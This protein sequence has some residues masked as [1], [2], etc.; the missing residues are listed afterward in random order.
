MIGFRAAEWLYASKTFAAAMLALAIGFSANLDRP[1]WAM[2][3][4]YIASQPQAGATRSKAAYRLMGTLLGAAAA[5]AMVPNLVATPA[6][7][8]GAL[9]GWVAITLTLAL[10]DRTPRGYVFML[11]GYS[12]AIIGFSSVNAPGAIFN[13]A[14]ARAEEIGVGV[15]CAAL[16]SSLVFPRHIG[17]VFLERTRKWLHD[18]Q[19]WAVDVLSQRTLSAAGEADRR[20]LAGD[21]IDIGVLTTQL[22][23]DK[24]GQHVSASA[25]EALQARLLMLLPLLSSISARLAALEKCGAPPELPAILSQAARFIAAAEASAT[26]RPAPWLLPRLA[27]A[28]EASGWPEIL[29]AGLLE[30][31]RELHAVFADCGALRAHLLQ[32]RPGLP[33]LVGGSEI[34]AAALQHTDIRMA[35]F[36]GLSAGLAVVLVCVFWRQAAWPE[37]AVAAQMSA[38]A[39]C[40]FAAQ[41]DPAP[42]I[43]QFLRWTAVAVLVDAAYLFAIL[44]AIDGFAILAVALAPAFMLY[45]LLIARPRTAPVGLALA[46]NGATL[47]ALQGTYNADFASFANSSLAVVAGMGAAAIMTRLVRSVG[48]QWS[49]WR[50]VR[51]NWASLARAARRRGHGD[52]AAFAGLM[53]DRIGLAAARVSR[54]APH[55]APD[56]GAL[57]ADLRIGLNIVDL[58]RARHALPGEAVRAIDAALDEVANHYVALAAGFGKGLA[59]G[60]DLLA[61]IDAS[62]ASVRAAPAGSAR[63]DAMLGLVGLRLGLCPD[64]APFAPMRGAPGPNFQ[65]AA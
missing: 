24:G 26:E 36:S 54:I 42:A 47:L 64:A 23:F 43:M 40:F 5:V 34:E 10:L 15:I 48:A 2:A 6:L 37:G 9:A 57:M 56:T 29:L 61:R 12:A 52:R 45:G 50:L 38:V 51:S 53:M 62:I 13:V 4:V 46:A 58:R 18:G 41:D 31:L 21:V 14:L 7:L 8:V 32:G 30:R 27:A 3:T 1:Y 19:N 63:R 17:P 60:A 20:R 25:A 11:A 59:P 55:L 22:R 49:A 33:P 44:P 28:G 35:V 16:V 39:C 65:V